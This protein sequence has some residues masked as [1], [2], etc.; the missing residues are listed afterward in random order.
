MLSNVI[1]TAT[2]NNSLVNKR[3]A[4]VRGRVG[5]K[6]REGK[7]VDRWRRRDRKTGDEGGDER[8]KSG[9]RR[10][11]KGRSRGGKGERERV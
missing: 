3:G 8:E 6:G 5:D 11:R 4:R 7:M 2:K 10:V 1:T 9:R